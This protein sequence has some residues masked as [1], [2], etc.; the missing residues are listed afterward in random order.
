MKSEPK[1]RRPKLH[2]LSHMWNIDLLQTQQYYET[3]VT[4]RD[5]HIWKGLE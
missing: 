5:G 4:L 1:H 2:V 3:L